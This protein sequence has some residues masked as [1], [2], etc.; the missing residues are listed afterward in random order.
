MVIL[1]EAH[2]L[3]SP[4][5]RTSLYFSQ[6]GKRIPFRLA[7][8]GTPLPHSPLD[9][10]AMYRFLDPWIFGWGYKDFKARYAVM[11]GFENKQVIAY[12]NIDDLHRKMFSIAVR[13]KK[14]DVLDLPPAVHADRRFT[15]PTK[16]RKLYSDLEDEL[17]AQIEEGEVTAANALVKLLRLQQV[18]SGHIKLDDGRLKDV[19][20]DKEALLADLF[21]DLQGEPIVVFYRFRPDAKAIKRAATKAKLSCGEVSGD[22][23]DVAA[24]QGGEF[25]VLAAQVRSGSEGVDFTRSA[26]A[27]FFSVGFSL[28]EYEQCLA[29]LHRG[30]QTRSVTYYHLIAINTIDTRVYYALQKRREVVES[31]LTEMRAASRIAS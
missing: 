9:A 17:Y 19:H 12:Q 29:R 2:R 20:S 6:L 18:T 30:G 1:D 13:V 23:D 7:L 24:W 16:A 11:G 28:A 15:L 10:Y 26:Y 5:S 27:V 4:G 3:K 25:D 31:V 14:E 22:R 8:T 21:Q